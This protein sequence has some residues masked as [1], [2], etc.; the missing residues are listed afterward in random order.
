M[1]ASPLPR[2]AAIVIESGAG[3]VVT[4][5][6]GGVE[7]T[8]RWYAEPDLVRKHQAAARLW[9]E[10]TSQVRRRSTTSPPRSSPVRLRS[11]G[12]DRSLPA[13]RSARASPRTTA[14]EEK[15][16]CKYASCPALTSTTG[17]SSAAGTSVWHLAQVREGAMLGRDCIVGRGAYVG[18][19]VQLGDN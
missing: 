12:L 16:Q 3:A 4:R 14:Q 1:L 5:P 6:G 7:E 15:N 19:D 11:R 9:A 17:P 8:A 2:I 10:R 18:P 13:G